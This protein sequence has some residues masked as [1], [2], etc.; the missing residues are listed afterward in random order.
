MLRLIHAQVG[1]G[2]LYIDDIDDGLPNKEVHRLGSTA[3]PRAYARDGYANGA[4]QPCYIP[5]ANPANTT[6]PG[7]IDL[8]ETNRVLL[9]ASSGKIAG[10]LR[11]SLITVISLV[12]SDKLAPVITGTT[13]DSPA[14]GDITIAG[15]NFLSILPDVTSVTLAGAGV[16]SVTLTKAQIELVAPGAVT[17]TSIVIDSTLV[18][19]L[20]AGDTVVVH[21]DSQDSNTMYLASVITSIVLDSPAPGDMTINGLGF[22]SVV[23]ANTSVHLVGAGIGDVTRTR[24]QIIAVP[25]GAVS[26]TQIIIDSTLLTGLAG[27]DTVV[28]HSDGRDSNTYYLPPIVTGAVIDTPTAGDVT[29][30]GTGFLST[31]PSLTSVTL[32]GSVAGS[33]LTLAAADIITGGGSVADTQIVIA[34]G[35]VPGL[36]G[37]DAIVVTAD[38]QASNSFSLSPQVSGAALGAPAA[39]DIT[40]DGIGFASVVPANTSVHLVGPG[41]GDVT[42][43]QAAIVAVP[44]GAVGNT[45][46]IIDSTLVPALAVGDHLMVTADGTTSLDYY[47]PSITTALLGVPG[48]GD[49]TITGVGLNTAPASVTLTGAVAGSP[50]TLTA[51]AIIAGGGTV[52]STQIVIP[53]ALAPGLSGGDTVV[54]TSG[55]QASN[56]FNLAPVITAAEVDLPGVGDITIDGI[57]FAGAGAVVRLFGPGIGDVNRTQAQILAAGG[58]AAYGD[59]QIV[60]PAAIIPF[61][62]AGDEVTVTADGT[63]S[64]AFTVTT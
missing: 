63:T 35:D 31:L 41:I 58:V 51:A 59:I 64:A 32:T 27:G 29:I 54:V 4:K 44:P 45:Q 30:T 18:P 53:T 14:A 11:A 55:G 46:I 6:Q 8:D 57:G 38:G 49:L 40:I 43:G 5:Y 3:D 52:S 16:G 25:P 1:L 21:A 47:L 28:V 48:A 26:D 2:A 12:A 13:L 19:G 62:A 34:A 20:Q 10:F 39:G 33:P 22:A 17:N 61:L 42:L 7:Y 15:L 9:S 50:L 56:T 24:A 36:A 37:G 60:I 23:P